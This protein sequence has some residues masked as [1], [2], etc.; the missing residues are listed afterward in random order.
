MKKDVHFFMHEIGLIQYPQTERSV[1]VL[2]STRARRNFCEARRIFWR[3]NFERH[4]IFHI[5]YFKQQSVSQ[6]PHNKNT[7]AR[8]CDNAQKTPNTPHFATH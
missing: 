5:S 2:T 7:D 6:N 8:H 1:L 4:I 3:R